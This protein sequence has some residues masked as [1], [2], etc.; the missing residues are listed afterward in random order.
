MEIFFQIF[1]PTWFLP[2]T[3][4]GPG[5]GGGVLPRSDPGKRRHATEGRADSRKF[6]ASMETRVTVIS[7]LEMP[8]LSH[9]GKQHHPEGARPS[10]GLHIGVRGEGWHSRRQVSP[11][12]H[13][14]VSWLT[15][16]RPELL[17]ACPRVRLLEGPSGWPAEAL[18]PGKVRWLLVAQ[19]KVVLSSAENPPSP[20]AR[21]S[22][23]FEKASMLGALCLCEAITQSLL[24]RHGTQERNDLNSSRLSRHV[25]LVE[26]DESQGIS[27]RRCFL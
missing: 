1:P 24:G 4:P 21:I 22:G 2:M 19:P 18:E 11:G 5:G 8:T 20:W 6:I 15:S 7:V 27:E 12:Q 13:S 3:F 26:M 16:P 14:T 25:G 10:L 9:I 23:P 17:A